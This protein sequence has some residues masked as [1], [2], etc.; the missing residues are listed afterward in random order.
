MKAIVIRIN[1]PGGS[2]IASEVIWR[3]LSEAQKEK[4]LIA[5][6]SNYAASGGYYIAAPADTIVAY[7]NTI[8]GSIGIL[9]Y[10][11]MPRDS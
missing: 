9:V 3:E 10:G 6:M 4:P 8:T 11:L 2:V 5:S 7:P 1:S